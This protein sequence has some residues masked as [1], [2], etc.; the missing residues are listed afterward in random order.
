M[1][2]IVTRLLPQ[3]VRWVQLLQPHGHDGL[4]LP[5]IEV[6]ALTDAS[7]VLAV[8]Q[9]LA[10]Y[11]AVMFVS[12]PAVDGF[13]NAGSG[14]ASD[15]AQK[16]ALPARAWCTGPGTRAALVRHGMAPDAVDAPDP[17]AE[18]LDSEAL[19]QRVC[20]QI[21]PGVRILI[22]RGDTLGAESATADAP[23]SP[24]SNRVGVGRDWL[25]Q[26]LQQA[27]AQV[28]FVVA[29]R[30]CLP[31]WSEVQRTQALAAAG[32][33]SVWLFSSAEAVG[34]LKALLPTQDWSHA[35]AI[36]THGRIATAAQ[37]LGFP[38]VLTSRPSLPAVL[39]S[40]ESIHD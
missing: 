3:A 28:D 23:S 29:Y 6:A 21:K 25:A 12:S 19:W 26:R 17:G 22:V 1:R 11:A 32:D 36:A 10:R 39:A 18:Q 4:A 40:L 5:L 9:Q 34:N 24:P 33:G 13:F 30:R 15:V 8:R 27:G 35:R 38:V 7:A 37:R 20:D 14:L 31:R 2:V 16:L